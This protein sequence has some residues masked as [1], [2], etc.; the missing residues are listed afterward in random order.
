VIVVVVVLIVDF[1][2][3]VAAAAFSLVPIVKQIN[4]FFHLHYSLAAY[5]NNTSN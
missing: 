2:V 3:V 4:S 5:F 1:V